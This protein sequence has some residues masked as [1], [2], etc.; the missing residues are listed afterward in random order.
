MYLFFIRP[1]P[2]AGCLLCLINIVKIILLPVNKGD[3]TCLQD[4]P[5][6][7][8]RSGFGMLPAGYNISKLEIIFCV[9]L[10]E[11]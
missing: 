3:S 9:F 2:D 5:E 4:A 7:T 6:E 8:Q 11:Q 10:A 1:I